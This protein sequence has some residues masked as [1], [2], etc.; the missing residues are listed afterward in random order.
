MNHDPADCAECRRYLGRPSDGGMFNLD[1][2]VE[3]IT[4]E[5]AQR[6]GED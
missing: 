3:S 6:P 1:T 5:G 2:A 4:E